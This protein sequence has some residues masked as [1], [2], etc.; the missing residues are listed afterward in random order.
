MASLY[1]GPAF[2]LAMHHSKMQYFYLKTLTL[3]FDILDALIRAMFAFLLQWDSN[4]QIHY[5]AC[6][7]CVHD[8]LNRQ[9][10]NITNL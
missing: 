8:S 4:Q 6:K 7:L 3:T 2:C 1:G 5:L 10:I 9:P